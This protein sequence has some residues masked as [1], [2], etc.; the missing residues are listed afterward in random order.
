MIT[1]ICVQILVSTDKL[2]SYWR[3]PGLQIITVYLFLYY[4]FPI[5]VLISEKKC[6]VWL[7]H[8]YGRMDELRPGLCGSVRRSIHPIDR[9]VVGPILVGAHWRK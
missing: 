3:F 4:I 9:K 5:E 2:P 6:S 7:S 1:L 8:I